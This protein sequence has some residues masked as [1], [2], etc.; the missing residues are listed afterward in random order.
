MAKYTIPQIAKSVTAGLV[1]FVGAAAASAGGAD[2]SVLEFGQWMMSLGAGLTAFGTT[3]GVPNAESTPS[4]ETA[5]AD[6]ERATKA[7]QAVEEQR[8]VFS[9]AAEDLKGA[10]VSAG[11]GLA[12][13]V[14][15]QV[16]RGAK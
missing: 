13:D 10:L 9:K 5:K 2:L 11:T 1:A 3:F 14:F 12:A 4:A 7:V 8:D 16:L 6:V 15:T